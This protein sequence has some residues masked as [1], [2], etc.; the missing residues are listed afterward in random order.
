MQ[1]RLSMR[2]APNLSR[3]AKTARE[4]QVTIV[5]VGFLRDQNN[6]DE[7]GSLALQLEGSTDGL[8][9]FQYLMARQQLMVS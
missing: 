4:A 7:L 1:Q 6:T 2:V 3:V 8:R 9:Y 5:E